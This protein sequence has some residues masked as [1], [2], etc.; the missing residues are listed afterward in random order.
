RVLFRSLSDPRRREAQLRNSFLDPR[1]ERRADKAR[2]V[3][4]IRD[5][6]RRH[7]GET[8]NV[9]DCRVRQGAPFSREP[10]ESPGNY[11]PA[12]SLA[13]FSTKIKLAAS[14]PNGGLDLVL[15]RNRP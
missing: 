3:D 15:S 8:R 7:P 10:G 2:P 6:R 12:D 13:A 1:L 4:D 14:P 11:S 5:R 9:L